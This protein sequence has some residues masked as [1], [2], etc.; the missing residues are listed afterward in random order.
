MKAITLHQP[1]A[2]L[3]AIG[4]KTIETR[5]WSTNYRGQL[6][7][8]AAV[9]PV[10]FDRTPHI[11]EIGGYCFGPDWIAEMDGRDGYTGTPIAGLFGDPMPL[12]Q[13]VATCEL[14]DV[15]RIIP[16]LP[17]ADLAPGQHSHNPHDAVYLE[18]SLRGELILC[19]GSTGR[20]YDD[21]LP[22][23]DFGAGRFAWL[24]A[25]VVTCAQPAKGKQ[26]LWNWEAA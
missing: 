1:W 24:L 9:K 4:A 3:V 7:I 19:D 16:R 20:H 21:Q 17:K 6:A 25:D 11:G 23:G 14:V 10:P 5:S 18:H 2:Q 26:G 12:G 13:V 22:Y 8:H 15:V